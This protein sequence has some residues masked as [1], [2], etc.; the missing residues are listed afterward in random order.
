MEEEKKQIKLKDIWLALLKNKRFFIKGLCATFVIACFLTLSVPNYYKA[1]VAL[2]PEMGGRGGSS[3][4]LS[5]LASS[6]GVSIGSTSSGGDAISPS[7]YPDMMNSVEFKTSLFPIK[8]HEID[9][10]EEMTYY[11]YLLDH[12]RKPWWSYILGVRKVLIRTVKGL[13]TAKSDEE[14]DNSVVDPFQLTK[15]QNSI[16][17]T[18]AKKI[19]CDVNAKTMV[20]SIS[21]TDQDPLVAAVM[22]DSVKHRLQDAITSYRTSKV[23]VD[24]E[25]N[26]KLYQETKAR[27][28]D[29]RQKYAAYADANQNVILQRD[30]NKLI[31][32]ENEMQL[33]YQAYSTVAAQL[34]AAEAKVQEAT[35]AFTILQNV[36]VP[37]EKAGPRRAK[38]V[39]M[40][41]FFVFLCMCAYVLHKEKYLIPLVNVV[42]GRDG[43]KKENNIKQS[44]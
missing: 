34:Q 11:D 38:I 9:C 7:L 8:V 24:L 42:L 36:T 17:K 12:Q 23:R 35:P 3:S 39:I 32:L 21:V 43:N 15:E 41:C 30:R 2:A 33:R 13:F 4:S 10:D 1:S 28:D 16:I 14:V 40:L 22:A 5:S 18:M 29:A 37:I 26:K 20:I 25:Y 6:F 44:V 31:E 19:E 27:Y